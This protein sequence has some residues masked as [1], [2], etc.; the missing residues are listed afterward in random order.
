MNFEKI[1]VLGLGYIGLPTASTFASHGIKV[2]GVDVNHRIV[3]TLQNGEIHIHEPGLRTLVQAAIRSGNLVISEHPE[4]ADAFI[5]AV[6]TPF[7]ADKTADLGYVISAS[8]ALVPY[9]RPGNLVVLESTSPPRTTVDIV[10]PIL[11]KSG[12]KAGQD[13]YVAYT[14]ER[15]LPGQILR[16]LIENA[17]VIGG[18]D[19]SSAEAGRDLY[20]IFVRGEIFLTDATTAE[21]VKLM[22]N[23]Y[24][25]VNIAIANE[26]SRLADR[27]GVDVWEAI[28]L[29]NRH[30]R[31]NILNPGPGVGGHCISV[32]PWFFVG[33]APDLAELIRT[34]RTV[35]DSQ[36]DFVVRLFSKAAG[37]TDSAAY[38]RGKRVALLGLAYKPDVDDLRESPAI[39]IAHKLVQAGAEVAAYEPF[40]LDAEVQG[41]RMA[42]TLEE[43]IADA[44][45]IGVLVAHQVFKNVEPA[46]IAVQTSSRLVIDTVNIWP[47]ECWKSAG[48]SIYHLGDGKNNPS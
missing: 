10:T 9:L 23:T 19:P 15:V 34:A 35:N 31:V 4:E 30:P 40:K 28:G 5:I 13:F 38:L 17:R 3:Q 32:D 20:K 41:I 44:D 22:E 27:F 18:I 16:E 12:L 6:P 37:Q 47:A 36:P 45:L 2:I 21:M 8:E 1:C 33:A 24:R 26:F 7:Y 11:E 46:Q 25:D 42:Q 29:A 48:F 43:A 39:E 14:P